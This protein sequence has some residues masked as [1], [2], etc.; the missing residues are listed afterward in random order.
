MQKKFLKEQKPLKIGAYKRFKVKDRT[1][2]LKLTTYNVYMLREVVCSHLASHNLQSYT[3][4][5]SRIRTL[6]RQTEYISKSLMILR[7]LP[8]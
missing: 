3:R 7:A 2:V 5:A 4:P 8:I 6:L 1:A